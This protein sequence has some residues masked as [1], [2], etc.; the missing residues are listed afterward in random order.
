MAGARRARAGGSGATRYTERTPAADRDGRR[1]LD[2]VKNETYGGDFSLPIY[3]TIHATIVSRLS[4]R[5]TA[6]T[7]YYV[8]LYVVL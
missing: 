4:I 2:T 8:W 6:L 1:V 7:T 5:L 3:T